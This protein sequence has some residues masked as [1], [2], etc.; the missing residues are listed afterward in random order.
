MPALAT[1]AA[2][3]TPAWLT[4]TLQAGG[5]LTH[6]AV[7]DAEIERIGSGQLGATYLVTPTYDADPAEAP[8][9]L[10]A[11]LPAVD[12]ASRKYAASLE[13][14]TREVAFY[15][16]LASELSVRSPRCYHADVSPEGDIATLLLEDLTPATEVGQVEGCGAGQA[17]TALEQAAALHGSSWHRQDLGSRSWLTSGQA[18]WHQLGAASVQSPAAFLA[19][20]EGA[21]DDVTVRVARAFESGIGPRFAEHATRPVCLWHSD[22]RL[23]N[24]LFDARGGEVPLAV[25]DWQS[26]MLGN[27]P[28]DASYFIGAGLR[29][30]VRREH[31]EDLV[32]GYHAA[33]R[34]H[35]VDDYDWD[36]CWTEYRINALAGFVIA[37]VVS[38]STERSPEA[39]ALFT[40]MAAR[41]AAHIEDH[42][43]VALLGA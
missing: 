35:G 33:L 11:K 7:T 6:A 28:I 22:F 15:R 37:M 29:T 18:V 2:D 43:A 26:V 31:E 10:V 39:D 21:L 14:Y 27:G 1:T 13:V 4:E 9:R 42:D 17:R 40:T 3:L 36:R 41:H 25:L 8:Q 16:S 5:V 32:R 34:D 20:H 19:R 23:D 30:E 12:E 24:L 38:L